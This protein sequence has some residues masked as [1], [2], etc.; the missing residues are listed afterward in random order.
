M[1]P[2][3]APSPPIQSQGHAR[4]PYADPLPLSRVDLYA[5]KT[6]IVSGDRRFTYAE[7]GERVRTPRRRTALRRASSPATASPTS[8]STPSTA[9]RLLRAP[10]GRAPSSMPLNVRLTPAEMTGDSQSCRAAHRH[11]RAR[12][13]AARRAAAPGLPGRADLGG[14][15]RTPTRNCSPRGRIHRP[16]PS[17]STR[18]RNRRALLHQRV[19]RHA[20]GRDALAPH[21]L[22]ARA[23]GV[24]ATFSQ[25]R[26]HGGTAHHPA[27]PRQRLGT[28]RSAPPCTG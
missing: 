19:H 18:T 7:F 25:R 1:V 15:R 23:L 28:R 9:R 17:P 13:R 24:S 10:P 16:D 12:F 20:Q 3:S 2:P 11:L 26:H 8:A 4:A 6:G 21:A 22:P 27:L 14:N 5:K